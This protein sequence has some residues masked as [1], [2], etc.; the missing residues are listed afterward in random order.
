MNSDRAAFVHV[1]EAITDYQLAA[2]RLPL[3]ELAAMVTTCQHSLGHSL[4]AFNDIVLAEL[5]DAEPS[6]AATRAVGQIM[7]EA[8]AVAILTLG[9]A[10]RAQLI[11]PQ[12]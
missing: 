5:D 9:I 12:N 1:A 4:N 8:T 6:I 2:Q 7:R 3:P 10:H 11:A